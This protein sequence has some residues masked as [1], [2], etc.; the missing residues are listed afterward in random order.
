MRAKRA[1]SDTD[2]HGESR[3]REEEWFHVVSVRGE[4]DLEHIE[5]EDRG[6]SGDTVAQ[7]L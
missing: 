6:T 2:S 3:E 5:C 4:G 7:I 1:A